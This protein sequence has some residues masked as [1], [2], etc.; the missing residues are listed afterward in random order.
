MTDISLIKVQI[1]SLKEHPFI[2]KSCPL[3]INVNIGLLINFPPTGQPL[4]S[5]P[6]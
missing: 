6:P 4:W 2:E 5:F 1:K 3:L